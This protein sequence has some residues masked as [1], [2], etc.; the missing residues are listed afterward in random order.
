MENIVD[1]FK[2]LSDKTRL[3]ILRLLV[4]ARGEICSCEICDSLLEPQYSVSRNIK[5]LKAAG[6]IR[7]HKEGKWVY[8]SLIKR[9]GDFQKALLRALGTLPD[10]D[11][12]EKD[13]ARFKKR[14]KLREDGKCQIGIQNKELMS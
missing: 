14:L 9:T 7:E 2:A 4:K 8:Y 11:I 13:E 3:R 12:L 1:I 5:I 10:E 6:L